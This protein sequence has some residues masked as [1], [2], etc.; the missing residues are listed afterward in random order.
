VG[1]NIP[2]MKALRLLPNK[3]ELGKVEIDANIECEE[4]F[5][6]LFLTGDLS[7]RI[8]VDMLLDTITV[9]QGVP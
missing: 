5:P 3:T 8:F 6:T 1:P 7:R 2:P 9:R 4:I